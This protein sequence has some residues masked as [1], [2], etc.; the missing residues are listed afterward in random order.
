MTG[1]NSAVSSASGLRAERRR[2]RPVMVI[3][4]DMCGLLSVSGEG[5]EN[6]VQGG[7]VY[8]EIRD[9]AAAWVGLV[10]QGTYLR[11]AAVGRYADGQVGR[12]QVHRALVEI[13]A[14]LGKGHRVRARQVEPPGGDPLLQLGGR[15]LGDQ[16]ARVQDRDPVG[17]PVGLL[18]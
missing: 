7:T 1:R 11:G 8:G 16:V 18:P 17:Q 2:L 12:V 10:Q 14:D 9:Q 15:S 4:S 6:V 3:A 5:E 13:A